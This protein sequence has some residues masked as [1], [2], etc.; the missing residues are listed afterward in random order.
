MT[1][2]EHYKHAEGWLQLA[3]EHWSSE[4]SYDP[5]DVEASLELHTEARAE[6]AFYVQVAQAHATLA[7]AAEGAQ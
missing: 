6:A 1:G 7:Q 4:E 3:E 5:N 2:P